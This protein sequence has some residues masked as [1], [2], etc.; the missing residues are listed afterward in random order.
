MSLS[1]ETR[2]YEAP[3][4]CTTDE[5]FA[6]GVYALY[7]L[8]YFFVIPAPVGVIIAH[9]QVDHADP[10]MQSH[11]R[12]Q[13]RTFWIGLMY[14]VIGFPLC[15]VLIGFPILGWWFVWSL[16]RMVKGFQLVI[17]RKPIVNP[18]SWL[19]G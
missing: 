18:D 9:A 3:R 11:Y 13:I 17:D 7:F 8:G 16:I 5:Y 2:R 4:L 19:F 1:Y 10:V 14:N 15:F 6:V 12:F